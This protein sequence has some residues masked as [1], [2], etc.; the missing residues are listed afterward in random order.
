[1]LV[2]RQSDCID[3]GICEPECP[4]EAI[5][6]DSHPSAAMWINLNEKYSESWPNISDRREPL[7]DADEFK[8]ISNKYPEFFSPLP[9]D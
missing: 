6:P 8:T 4:V 3:C 7:T 1:M 9:A 5:I 2:I